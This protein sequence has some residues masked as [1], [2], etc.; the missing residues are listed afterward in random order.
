MFSHLG[1]DNYA[2]GIPVIVIAVVG[3]V[4]GQIFFKRFFQKDKIDSCHEVG[5]TILQLLG[6]LYA[7][8]LGLIVL[9]A[10]AKFD[11]A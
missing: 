10:T 6:T 2:I 8:T 11:T 9:D 1:L 3:F 5:G 4:I 7:V